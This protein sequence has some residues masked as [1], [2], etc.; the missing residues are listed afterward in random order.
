MSAED[1]M[2]D[3]MCVQ[4]LILF[5]DPY[6]CAFANPTKVNNRKMQL[7]NSFDFN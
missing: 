4:Y 6:F 3:R 1:T 2:Y 5:G 7:E